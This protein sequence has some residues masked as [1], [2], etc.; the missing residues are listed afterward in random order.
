MNI[1]LVRSGWCITVSGIICE[2]S[3]FPDF[4]P[5][6]I[7]FSTFTQPKT[8]KKPHTPEGF[9]GNNIPLDGTVVAELVHRRLTL[10][11][12]ENYELA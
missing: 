12:G 4:I 3:L 2:I 5:C 9:Q 8:P 6:S 1:Q 7:Y 11:S 10:D